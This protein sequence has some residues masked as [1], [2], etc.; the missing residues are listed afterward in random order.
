ML[1]KFKDIVPDPWRGQEGNQ[2]LNQITLFATHQITGILISR[3]SC[4]GIELCQCWKYLKNGALAFAYCPHQL[5]MSAMLSNSVD[6][7]Y[8][9]YFIH[10][11]TVRVILEILDSPEN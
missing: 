7:K 11:K 8:L 4:H 10:F 1:T 5:C 9:T 3:S 2:K 6:N